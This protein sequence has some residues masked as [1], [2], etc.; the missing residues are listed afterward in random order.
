LAN[1]SHHRFRRVG[2][3]LAD[4][5]TRLRQRKPSLTRGW[6]GTAGRRSAGRWR[7]LRIDVAT[8]VP[9]PLARGWRRGQPSLARPRR[10][11]ARRLL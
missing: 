8:T 1:T 7:T 6:S 9:T 5:D 11:P 10:R 4:T 3:P 2:R